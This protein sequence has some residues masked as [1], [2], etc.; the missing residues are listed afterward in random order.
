MR[1]L[2]AIIP[3][4]TTSNLRACIAAVQTHD[5]RVRVIVVD[6]GIDWSQVDAQIYRPVTGIKPFIFSRNVNRGILAAEH[7]ADV[8]VLNDDALLTSAGGFTLL[9]QTAE[10]NP[11][12]GLVAAACTNVGNVNQNPKNTG[13]LRD[14]PRMVCFT[15]VLI[16]ARTID[17][18]GLLDERFI[19]YGMDDDDYCLRVRNAGLKIGIHDG[20]VVDHGSL[21]STYRGQ[22]GGDFRANLEIFKQ[23]WGMDNFG[24]PCQAT[25]QS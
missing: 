14:E 23:K 5:P 4:R 7:N 20:C 1:N 13:R 6:D 22:G 3:S 9:Q 2:Y 10:E 25:I 21:T 15:S 8:L 16:P 11:Q 18:V 12:Y 19:H 17:K 24:K